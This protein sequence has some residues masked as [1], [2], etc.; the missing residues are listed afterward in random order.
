MNNKSALFLVKQS[1]NF[2]CKFVKDERLANLI[3]NKDIVKMKNEKRTTVPVI[4]GD[5]GKVYMY[6]L[7]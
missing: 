6:I 2:L 4:S 5:V 3:H 1:G 7:R